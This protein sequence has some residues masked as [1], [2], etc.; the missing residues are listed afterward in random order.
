MVKGAINDFMNEFKFDDKGNCDK[1]EY[2]EVFIKIGKILIPG[3][4]HEDLREVVEQ[5]FIDDS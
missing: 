4:E 2:Y 5:D 3:I 1:K